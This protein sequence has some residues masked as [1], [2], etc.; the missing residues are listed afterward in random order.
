[1]TYAS[2]IIQK[3]FGSEE[4][5]YSG[6]VLDSGDAKYDM[7]LMT[8]L[9]TPCSVPALDGSVQPNI[10]GDFLNFRPNKIAAKRYVLALD[11]GE[12][13]KPK[14]QMVEL[15]VPAQGKAPPLRGVQLVEETSRF[16]GLPVS[17]LML[18]MSDGERVR[19]LDCEPVF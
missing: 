11:C 3:L 8:G 10:A 9:Y 18:V 19:V 6:D 2:R 15:Y 1:M 7:R 4:K 17:E 14:Q 13:G 16:F 5:I 12:E